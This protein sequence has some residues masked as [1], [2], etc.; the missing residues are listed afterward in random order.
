[1]VIRPGVSAFIRCAEGV[2]LQKRDD[3]GLWG[4]PGGSVEPGESITE[5]VVREVR[6][7]T[8][9]DVEPVRLIGVYSSPAH[10]QIVT[11]ADGNVI[12]YISSSFECRITGGEIACG[13]ES[14]ACEWFLPDRLPPEHLRRLSPGGDLLRRAAVAVRA[15]PLGPIRGQGH[16]T[17]EHQDEKGAEARHGDLLDENP[18]GRIASHASSSWATAHCRS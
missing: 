6:E 7:E 14:L 5:A 9:L 10:H 1:M 2:L 17:T 11:Y 4:L 12:H 3:N 13:P 8:G 18:S 16:P 15:E